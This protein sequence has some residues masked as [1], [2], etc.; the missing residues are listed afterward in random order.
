MIF[1]DNP[2]RTEG[3]PSSL[4]PADAVYNSLSAG[5]EGVAGGREWMPLWWPEMEGERD[6][7]GERL[8]RDLFKQQDN[9]FEKSIERIWKMTNTPLGPLIAAARLAAT[10]SGSVPEIDAIGLVS[11]LPSRI[12][13]SSPDILSR[14]MK[15]LD[16][17]VKIEI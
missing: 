9:Q 12:P 16:M 13:L 14:E 11:G 15:G 7:T 5:T 4:S 8:G 17:M 10:S 1:L 2:S 3:L 6:I